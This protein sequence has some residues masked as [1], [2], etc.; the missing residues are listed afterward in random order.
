MRK[1]HFAVPTVQTKMSE[2]DLDKFCREYLQALV[3]NNLAV[4][5][6][7]VHGSHDG[8]AYLAK[9]KRKKSIRTD[10]KST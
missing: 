3:D 7:T 9:L 5:F 10:F 8:S 2:A 4:G 1:R 6:F